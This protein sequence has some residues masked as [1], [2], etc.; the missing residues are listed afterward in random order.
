MLV[1]NAI[2]RNYKKNKIQSSLILSKFQLLEICCECLL[3]SFFMLRII[4][5]E[6]S[7]N[8]SSDFLRN[9]GTVNIFICACST[10]FL[11]ASDIVEIC[12]SSSKP[13]S[14]LKRCCHGSAS[15]MSIFIALSFLQE[16]ISALNSIKL[17]SIFVPHFNSNTQT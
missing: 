7:S 5:S 17:V 9:S 11:R 13:G 8:L 4:G 12:G 14:L 15:L 3:S 1:Q 16:S 2:I 6:I 10:I